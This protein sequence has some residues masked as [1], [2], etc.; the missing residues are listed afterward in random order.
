MKFVTVKI[1][2]EQLTLNP[3]VQ[4]YVRK[5]SDPQDLNEALLSVRHGA[6]IERMQAAIEDAMD[7]RIKAMFFPPPS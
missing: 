7:E 3:E 1:C 5:V 6:V 2:R 4:D